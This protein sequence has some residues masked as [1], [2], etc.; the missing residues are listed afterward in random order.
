MAIGAAEALTR[1]A[2]EVY[3]RGLDVKTLAQL[4]LQLILTRVIIMESLQK[5]ESEE[6][7]ERLKEELARLEKLERWI[8]LAYR[9]LQ[10]RSGIRVTRT[11]PIR[12]FPEGGK[13]WLPLY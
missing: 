1:R 13:A 11:Y 9:S 6:G 10:A 4:S 5:E 12:V 3:I 8:A 7:K 2:R